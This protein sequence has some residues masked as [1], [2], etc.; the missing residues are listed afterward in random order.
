MDGGVDDDGGA[1]QSRDLSLCERMR[2]ISN[3][4]AGCLIFHH[5]L[6]RVS[7]TVGG[8]SSSECLDLNAHNYIII[9]TALSILK[10]GANEEAVMNDVRCRGVDEVNRAVD[11][12]TFI[13]MPAAERRICT[14]SQDVGVGTS[15]AETDN[16]SGVIKTY[17][18]A[19]IAALVRHEVLPVEKDRCVVE[20][21]F[22]MDMRRP[23]VGVPISGQRKM[24]AIPTCIPREIALLEIRIVVSEVAKL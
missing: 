4:S 1:S 11:A 18:K 12:T 6:K 13:P 14:D 7:D 15:C 16:A 21:A 20:H 23:S 5:K 2:E 22:E 19:S 17:G 10:N 3:F 24:L 9:N 8:S